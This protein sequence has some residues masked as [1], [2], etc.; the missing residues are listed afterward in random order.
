MVRRRWTY[1]NR[2]DC[3]RRLA[4]EVVERVVR[5]ARENP[6]WGY[7]RIVGECAKLGLRVSATSVRTIL[8][9]RRLGPAP[10]RAGPSWTQFLRAQAAST[11]ACDFLTVETF[12]LTALYVLFFI[13]LDRRH[14]WLA[15]VTA[16]PDSAW[17]VQQARKLAA[18]L[19]DRFGGFKFLIRDRDDKFTAGFDAVFAA[20]GVRVIKTPVRTPVA[21][22][23]SERWI[24]SA[25][26]E[27][28]DWVLVWN[29]CYLERVLGA[30]LGHYNTGRPHR[31]IQ[32]QSPIPGQ[33][34]ADLTR[35]V[36]RVNIL[37]GLVHE[38]RRAA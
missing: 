16:H 3:S 19:G 32:L 26:N 11:L 35:P 33:A 17:V 14:V 9:R 36:E 23:Y 28:L 10:R 13:E 18:E 24:R 21:N 6:R 22:A 29:R 38:Y 4:P 1:P 37:G 2:R 8:R 30:Y 25:R 20:D 5:L 12:G 15:G 31:G 34:P 7:V 27:C